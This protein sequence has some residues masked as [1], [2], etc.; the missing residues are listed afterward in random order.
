[1]LVSVLILAGI[2]YFLQRFTSDDQIITRSES[3]GLTSAYAAADAQYQKL[4]TDLFSKRI[5]VSDVEITELS[6][7]FSKL[8]LATTEFI[9]RTGS[10]TLSLTL[11]PKL[12]THE[13]N[14]RIL[15]QVNQVLAAETTIGASLDAYNTCM[16]AINYS[17][18]ASTVLAKVTTCTSHLSSAQ[19]ELITLPTE[20]NERCSSPNTPTKIVTAQFN[21]HKLLLEY[22]RLSKNQ[23][24]KEAARI[25]INY[26]NSLKELEKF[27]TWNYC[28]NVYLQETAK[29]VGIK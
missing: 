21:S 6:T 17:K 14:I 11:V 13:E 29:E 1:M 20:V 5:S 22:Y 16:D 27:P 12:K 8:H 23:Q 15:Q 25:D 10:Y 19:K 24:A 28:I 2:V 26:K 9:Q 18:T 4:L 7:T 3:A